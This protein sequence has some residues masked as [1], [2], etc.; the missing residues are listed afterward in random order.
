[1]LLKIYNRNITCNKRSIYKKVKFVLNLEHMKLKFFKIN[2]GLKSNQ[3][4]K[5]EDQIE[6]HTI[7]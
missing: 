7:I 2:L 6:I 1:M 5:Y 3:I 4:N